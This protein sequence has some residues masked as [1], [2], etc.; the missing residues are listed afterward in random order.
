[1]DSGTGIARPCRGKAGTVIKYYKDKKTDEWLLHGPASELIEGEDVDFQTAK[2]KPKTERVGKILHTFADGNAIA[3]I[4]DTSAPSPARPCPHCGKDVN[5]KPDRV[6]AP[7]AVDD[8][9]PF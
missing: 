8:D 7:A 4:G 1:M 2:G 3:R 6:A 5:A 9:I